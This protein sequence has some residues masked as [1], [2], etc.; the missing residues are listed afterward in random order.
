MYE[1][2]CVL[3]KRTQ[4]LENTVEHRFT[5]PFEEKFKDYVERSVRCFKYFFGLLGSIGL[6]IIM[7]YNESYV[8]SMVRYIEVRLYCALS[9]F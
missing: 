5:A 6:E 4:K 1:V 2:G 7:L 3:L 8:V 9:E